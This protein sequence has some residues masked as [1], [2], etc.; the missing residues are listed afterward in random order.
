MLAITFGSL[1]SVSCDAASIDFF[2][3]PGS[4]RIIGLDRTTHS[5]AY[6]SKGFIRNTLW[7]KDLEH[8]AINLA[9]PGWVHEALRFAQDD[10]GYLFLVV[11]IDLIVY[12]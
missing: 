10:K 1:V 5:Q 6:D 7:N 2:L 8:A 9:L 11:F 4:F 3:V 12:P